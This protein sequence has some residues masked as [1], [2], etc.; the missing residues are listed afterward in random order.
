MKFSRHF[1]VKKYEVSCS[2]NFEFRVIEES[3]CRMLNHRTT[4]IPGGAIPHGNHQDIP[5]QYPQ[6]E[7]EI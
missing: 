3:C 7:G 6:L 4:K 1:S 5:V 2:I